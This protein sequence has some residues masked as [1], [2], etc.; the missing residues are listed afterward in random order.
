MLSE[1]IIKNDCEKVINTKD[2]G[3]NNKSCAS[4]DENNFKVSQSVY[5]AYDWGNG[6]I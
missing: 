2:K 6:M 1:R 4:A 5:I 3:T